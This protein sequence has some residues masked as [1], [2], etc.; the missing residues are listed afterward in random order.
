MLLAVVIH[1][2]DPI[3]RSHT[4]DRQ[5]GNE[6]SPL[7]AAERRVCANQAGFNPTHCPGHSPRTVGGS[8]LRGKH[9]SQTPTIIHTTD[10]NTHTHIYH[11]N[12]LTAQDIYNVRESSKTPDA[13]FFEM[14]P[15]FQMGL[16]YLRALYHNPAVIHFLF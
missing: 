16:F 14:L 6:K 12:L 15:P 2:H 7:P 9:I 8:T 10:A 3:S 5:E 1:S 11:D 13:G 4:R